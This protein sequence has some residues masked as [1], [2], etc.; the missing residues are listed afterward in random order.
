MQENFLAQAFVYLLAAVLSVPIAKRLGLGSV[1]GYLLAGVLIGPTVLGFVGG[2]GDVMHFAEFGV[3]V[4]LFIIGLELRPAL[5]WR[6]RGPILGVGGAQVLTT[7]AVVAF[8]ALIAGCR[9]PQA[10]AVGLIVAM[11]STAIVLQS[12]AEKG[13]LQTRGGQASFSV[14]LFQDIAVIPILAFMPLL[15]NAM[16]GRA[17]GNDHLSPIGGLPGWVQMLV[18][19]GAVAAVVV[20][21]RYLLR[22]VFRFIAKTKLREIFTASALAL[23]IG[24]ALLM[25][26]VGL[27][28]ALGT[29]LAG[30]VLADSEY[31]HQ[32]EADLEPFKGLLLGLFF[33]TV[34]AGIDFAL[35]AAQPGLIA[36]LV[37]ALIVIKFAVLLGLGLAFRF[38]WSASLLFAF[39]LAQGGEFCFVLLG[40]AEQQGVLPAE[41]SKPL[42]SAVALS[43]AATPLLLLIN[44]RLVQPCFARQKV[45]RPPDEIDEHDNPAILAGFGRFGHIVGRLLRANGFGVTVL[46]NDPDQVELLGRFGMKSFYGDATRLDLLRAAGADRAKLFV[47]AI[48]N[49]EKAVSLCRLVQ[50]EFP[51]MKIVARATSRQHAY[52]LMKLGLTHVHR[53]TF[54]SA[55]DLSED[56]LKCLGMKADQARRAALIFRKL[57]EEGMR[58]LLPH[59]DDERM[60]VSI[61]RQHIENLEN[62]LRDDKR[63]LTAMEESPSEQGPGKIESNPASDVTVLADGKTS[64]SPPQD[65]P[66]G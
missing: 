53:D 11:S 29:F 13:V 54:G 5:L 7:A 66:E 30:V 20:G 42:V 48:D 23:V 36:L 15:A 58:E 27:S 62:I 37:A 21:G 43:M 59:V 65:R 51:N 44:E 28:A 31:R 40:L 19:L 8:V 50:Q 49:D 6:L 61:A 64:A 4:M 38:D 3:V 18:T 2:S 46:D 45:E 14:L 60:Y 12:L 1:L 63:R 22:P 9:W 33:I 57:D 32:L 35:M 41:I 24:I 55:L 26:F 56:A 34:G 16:G 10:T 17:A 25:Q 39:A 47:C 52:D